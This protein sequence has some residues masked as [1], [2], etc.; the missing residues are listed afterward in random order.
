MEELVDMVAFFSKVNESAQSLALS[1]E[2]VEWELQS[3]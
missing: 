1:M 2:D 3:S